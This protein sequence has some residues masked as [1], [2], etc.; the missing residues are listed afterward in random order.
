MIIL[1][2]FTF[3]T[4]E[5]QISSGYYQ[6]DAQYLSHVH[7]HAVLK[8]YLHL[9]DIFNEETECEYREQ[10]K[11]CVESCTYLIPEFHVKQY[12]CNKDG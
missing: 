7:E 12:Y 2:F 5:N 6:W 4:S 8:I 9:L 11:A 10:C 1:C 3:D